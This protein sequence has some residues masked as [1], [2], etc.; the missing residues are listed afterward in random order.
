MIVAMWARAAAMSLV[1]ALGCGSESAKE[2]PVPAPKGP[3]VATGSG[4]AEAKV[5]EALADIVATT[6]DVLGTVEVRRKGS[7]TWEKVA[8][9]ATLRERDWVRTG[10]G[11]FARVRFGERG[12]VDLRE[13][14]TIIVDT[15][16][17]VEAGT[18]TGRAE[19]GSAL[20]V[21][22][23]DGSEAKI[24]AVEGGEAA[25]FRL[26]PSKD[27]GVEVAVTKGAAK[28][29]TSAGETQLKAGQASDVAANKASAVVELIAFPRSVAP[30]IDARFLFV[31]DKPIKIAWA[32]VPGASRY[33]VQIAKDTEFREMRMSI[34]T[35]TTST[36]FVPD[37]FGMYAWRIAARDKKTE[38]LSEYGFARRIFVEESPPKDL[39]LA[40]VDG[41]KVGF[42]ESYPRIAFSWQSPGDADQFK[43]VIG[44][45]STP[46]IDTVIS[47]PTSDQRVEVGTLREGAYRWGVYAIR[48]GHEEPIFI[49]P[50]L[51]TIRRQRV[52]AHTEKLWEDDKR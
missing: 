43:L 31:T 9:G 38:R 19:P 41:A 15:A 34:E 48:D 1:A 32:A 40:P 22:T 28:V 7:A 42:S 30:G 17:K 33:L 39:L 36:T 24:A 29:S 25:E 11:G 26:T 27:K 8:I 18:L 3:V 51:L 47:V 20:V 46:T 35:A 37:T 52:K 21:R 4:S 45:G 49:S 10:K 12:F 14:T 6:A 23:E 13:D 44:K 5:E 16:I 2:P 50:R